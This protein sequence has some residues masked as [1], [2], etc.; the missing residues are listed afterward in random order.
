MDDAYC[1][2]V[3]GSG[4]RS[5]H[6]AFDGTRFAAEVQSCRSYYYMLPSCTK[7]NSFSNTLVT[8]IGD[9]LCSEFR[10][11]RGSKSSSVFSVSQLDCD[12]L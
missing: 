6:F 10:G 3:N 2:V 8:M 9:F 5:M 12:R 1:A 4:E 7:T 11:G